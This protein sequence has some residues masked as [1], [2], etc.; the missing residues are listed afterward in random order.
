METL[1]I[2]VNDKGY[3]LIDPDAKKMKVA[4]DWK[5]MGAFED[6]LVRRLTQPAK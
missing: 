4:T 3:T 2:R 1:G 5:D 6:L